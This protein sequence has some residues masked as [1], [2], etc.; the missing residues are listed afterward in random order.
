[1]YGR[2]PYTLED[3][4]NFKKKDYK[5]ISESNIND[6]FDPKP[7]LMYQERLIVKENSYF[8]RLLNNIILDDYTKP[9][10]KYYGAM[11][12]TVGIKNIMDISGNILKERNIYLKEKLQIDK[13]IKEYSI[14]MKETFEGLDSMARN[15]HE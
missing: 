11:D 3:I 10:K 2:I 9:V 4:K 6:R 13:E 5:V 15:Y 1:V 12:E 7:L 8:K 14:W